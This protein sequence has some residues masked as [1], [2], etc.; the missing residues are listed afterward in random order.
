MK[1]PT[2]AL[3][4]WLPVLGLCLTTS[5]TPAE[6]DGF[7][8][9]RVSDQTGQ[10]T[11]TWGIEYREPL[12]AHWSGSF[13]WLNEGHVPNNHRDGQAVQVWWHTQ[14]G[15]MGLSFEAGLGPYLD[16][17]THRTPADSDSED[18]HGWGGLA[19]A[20]LRWDFARNWSTYLRVNEV[21]TSAK[22]G[23]TGIA[24]GVAYVFTQNFATLAAQRAVAE[25]IRHWEVDA[26][27]GAR[28]VNSFQSE[29]G[30]A[31]ALDLRFRFSRH[32]LASAT[33][34]TGQETSL[35]WTDGLALQLWLEQAL[36]EHVRAGVGAGAFIVGGDS[37]LR[38]E[39]SP[40]NLSSA[41]SVTLAYIFTPRWL[42][43]LTWTRLGTGDDH[44][45]D[46]LYAGAGYQL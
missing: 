20:D 26:L 30:S 21:D 11:Y 41:L 6:L 5:A 14:P 4:L 25:S 7:A 13:I 19:S 36:G 10:K 22:H 16:Y 45:C 31:E 29:S 28:I 39:S 34:V 46:L 32:V 3:L 38:S 17:D 40:E 18:R 37:S 33:L 15:P 44:D 27:L 9:G 42:G 23:S 43:R 12:S 24:A 2:G 35:N 1:K 8:G